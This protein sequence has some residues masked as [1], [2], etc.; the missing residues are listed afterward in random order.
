MKKNNALSLIATEEYY[1]LYWEYLKRSKKYKE[2][3]EYMRGKS[4]RFPFYDGGSFRQESIDWEK[5]T[6]QKIDMEVDFPNRPKAKSKSQ[7]L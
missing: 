4:F 2:L 3:C 7:Q 6:G 1:N 5:E